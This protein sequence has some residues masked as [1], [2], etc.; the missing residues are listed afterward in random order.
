MRASIFNQLDMG[1]FFMR[2]GFLLF[3]VIGI[4]FIAFGAALLI[5]YDQSFDASLP[6]NA[7]S[8]FSYNPQAPPGIVN[9]VDVTGELFPLVNGTTNSYLD[10]EISGSSFPANTTTIAFAFES[11]F[12]I[13]GKILDSSSGDGVGSW[14]TYN[15]QTS[16]NK[17]GT[18][19]I[20]EFNSTA[21]TRGTLYFNAE[22]SFTFSGLPYENNHGMYTIV[23]PFNYVGGGEPATMGF[24]RVCIP[25]DFFLTSASESYTL[26]AETCPAT[27]QNVQFQPT[28]QT[29]QLIM[30]YGDAGLQG[31][32]VAYQTF[33]LF[34]LGVG[35]PALISSITLIPDKNKEAADREKLAES[36]AKKLREDEEQWEDIW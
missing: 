25:N 24:F 7:N 22:I 26:P 8:N 20:L 6:S 2:R 33:G 3:V 28:Q 11:S 9:A 15:N 35:V 13:V 5:L 34:G 14:I 21:A 10:L 27:Y 31:K 17:P 4:V 29:S 23:Y 16:S 30:T 36:I 12:H 18:T 32:D 19:I 1:E